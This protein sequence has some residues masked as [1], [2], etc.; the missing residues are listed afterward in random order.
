MVSNLLT[1][2]D[3]PQNL[4]VSVSPIDS[5]RPTS[6]LQLSVALP[7]YGLSFYVDEDGDLQSCNMR[8]MVYDENQ[9]IGT[10]FGLVNRLV[11]RPKVRD[12][13]AVELVPRCVLIPEG[14]VSFKMNNHHVRVEINT[15]DRALQRVTYQTY[16]IDIELG[17]LTGNASLTNKLYCAYLH[18]L[19][20]GC[21]PDPLTGRL[22]TEEALSLLRSAGCWSVMKFGSREA[23][24]LSLVASLY[25]MRTWYPVHLRR[26]QKVGWLNLPA[27]S[28]HHELYTVSKSIKEHRERVQLFHESQSSSLFQAFPVRDDHLLGRSAQRAAYL[29]PSDVSGQ[30][31]ETTLDLWYHARDLIEVGEQRACIAATAV[32]HRTPSAT[33]AEHGVLSMAESWKRTVSGDA[34]LSLQYDKSWLAPDLPL[35]WLKAYELLR[36]DDEGK[37]YQLLFSLPA[38]AYA[39]SELAD[40][41]PVFVAF[42]SD[43]FFQLEDPPC[44]DSYK[45]AE[46][47]CPS[48]DT[49][50]GYVSDC[51]RSFECSPESDEPAQTGESP[52]SLRKRRL[53]MYNNR[54]D[55]D[56]ESTVD[57]LL[58]AWDARPCESPPLC[59]LNPTLY[60]VSNFMSNV[61]RQLS[62]C[63]RN[64]KLK[65]HL[66]R[67]QDILNDT[68]SQASGSSTHRY[69][70]QPSQIIPPRTSWLLTMDQLFVRP[71]PLLQ[72]RDKLPPHP[73]AQAARNT[74]F[75]RSAPLYRLISTVEANA[76]D[77]FQDRY[78]SALR[79]SAE[80]FENENCLGAQATNLKLPNSEILVAHYSRCKNTYTKG[81]DYVKQH[82]LPRSQSEIALE[83]S[84]Q[85]PRITAQTLFRSLASN[86]PTVLPDNWKVSLIRLTLL[87]LEVQRARRLLQLHFDN[88]PEELRRELQNEGCDGWDAEVHPDWLLIQVRF[89]GGG[90]TYR[91]TPHLSCKAVFW[92]V[93]FKLRLLMR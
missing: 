5:E 80:C 22:G 18:A 45:L 61:R 86:S 46:G 87:A 9:S 31:S 93:A 38:M 79:A 88:L 19:T 14:D 52:K 33:A 35:I 58:N 65:E 28:Q 72:A 89:S 73:L 90:I 68:Y 29:S 2:L 48:P 84:G 37:W 12:V 81:L 42:A 8:G 82:L 10:L 69:L 25:P 7:R 77:T 47:Y 11:L 39:S 74:T 67:V 75:S 32:H 36:R 15:H 53:K 83:L 20:S 60:D 63:Y 62:N 44:Y 16:R 30:P 70:F 66:D 54:R 13:G 27:S 26:M 64:L 41:V 92:S 71:A 17:C 43:P 76:I 6:L 1:P 78:V 51:A 40:L 3:I 91:L 85:W 55:S 49:L 24:L 4:L 50:R 57:R 34:T 21:G 56:A 23:E 59:S